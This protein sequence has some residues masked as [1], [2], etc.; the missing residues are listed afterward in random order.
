MDG[1]SGSRVE[2]EGIFILGLLVAIVLMSSF[3]QTEKDDKK[4]EQY[5]ALKIMLN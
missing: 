5:I 1:I 2:F 3:N 4:Y